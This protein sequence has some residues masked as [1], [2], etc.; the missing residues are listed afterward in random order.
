ML[1]QSKCTLKMSCNSKVCVCRIAR[2]DGRNGYTAADTGPRG[3]IARLRIVPR[4]AT[5]HTRRTTPHHASP[6]RTHA[7]NTSPHGNTKHTKTKERC[8]ARKRK[9]AGERLA[10]P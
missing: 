10:K 9:N 6:R 7:Q 1:G 3:G 5:L 8:T 4:S 2:R